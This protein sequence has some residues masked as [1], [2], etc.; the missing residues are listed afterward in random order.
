LISLGRNQNGQMILEGTCAIATLSLFTVCT[1]TAAYLGFA[2]MWIEYQLDRSLV[3]IA[4]TGESQMCLRKLQMQAKALLPFGTWTAD[5]EASQSEFTIRGQ[6]HFTESVD[7]K[8][9][10]KLD[11]E[12]L[13]L[14]KSAKMGRSLGL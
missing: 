2:S 7:W 1:L 4:S 6:F 5:A 10:K 3:C 13:A 12:N 9:Q 14:K 8:W 11:V